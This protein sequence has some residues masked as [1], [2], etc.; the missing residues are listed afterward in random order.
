MVQSLHSL[1]SSVLSSI[2]SNVPGKRFQRATVHALVIPL[3]A[4]RG[5][6]QLTLPV[7][8]TVLMPLFMIKAAKSGDLFVKGMFQARFK[9][10][11]KVVLPEVKA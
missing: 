2:K 4:S 10:A 6:G 1:N 3:G 8:G 7:I 5:A 11:E 9:G